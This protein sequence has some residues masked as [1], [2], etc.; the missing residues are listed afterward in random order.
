MDPKGMAGGVLANDQR[1]V[2]ELKYHFGAPR[3]VIDLTGEPPEDK[4]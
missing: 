4:L 2:K 1:K 3:Q